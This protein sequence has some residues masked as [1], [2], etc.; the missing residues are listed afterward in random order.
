MFFAALFAKFVVLILTIARFKLFIAVSACRTASA[1]TGS[2]TAPAF[3]AFKAPFAFLALITAFATPF[4]IRFLY[5]S[6]IPILVL[7]RALRMAFAFM[8]F[9]A[10]M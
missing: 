1:A 8:F 2:E 3:A 5:E 9:V 4:T 6:V 10:L 7:L